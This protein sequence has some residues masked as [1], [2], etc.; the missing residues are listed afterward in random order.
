MSITNRTVI[1]EGKIID[2]YLVNF[3]QYLD[4]K[5]N[6]I[7]KLVI[8]N[9]NSLIFNLNIS[10]IKYI[11][12]PL[13]NNNNKN[14][15]LYQFSI[16]WGDG[17]YEQYFNQQQCCHKYSSSGIYKIIIRGYYPNINTI[18]KKPTKDFR[19][20]LINIEQL[21]ELTELDYTFHDCKLLSGLPKQSMSDIITSCCSTFYGCNLIEYIP[22]EFTLPRFCKSSDSMF[23]GCINLT[24]F[25]N[26]N[27]CLPQTI[28]NCDYMFANTNIEKIPDHLFDTLYDKITHL[29]FV[30][31]ECNNLIDISNFNL[32][33]FTNLSSTIDLFRNCENLHYIAEDY[34]IPQQCK[35]IRGMFSNCINLT[36]C[37]NIIFYHDMIN[38][39]QVFHNCHKLSANIN[40]I[41]TTQMDYLSANL[42]STFFR[43][44]NL[45]GKA[46]AYYLWLTDNIYQQSGCFEQC[47][48]L[49]N[50]KSIPQYWRLNNSSPENNHQGYF[51]IEISQTELL[52]NNCP[53]KNS[54][55]EGI[56]FVLPIYKW[57]DQNKTQ[58]AKY[59][60]QINY[61]D[62]D[63]WYPVNIPSTFNDF[64]INNQFSA[65]EGYPNAILAMLQNA[66]QDNIRKSD[67]Y[68]QNIKSVSMY[69]LNEQIQRLEQIQEN[70]PFPNII[71]SIT[72][73]YKQPG[74]YIITI[75]GEC[76][77]L[78][79]YQQDIWT[80]RFLTKIYSMKNIS[81]YSI[82]H[83]FCN[84]FQLQK[85][86]NHTISTY[87]DISYAFYIK[88]G[89]DN[90]IKSIPPNFSYDVWYENASYAFYNCFVNYNIPISNNFIHIRGNNDVQQQFM[91]YNCRGLSGNIDTTFNN[92]IYEKHKGCFSYCNRLNGYIPKEWKQNL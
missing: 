1:K 61:G 47:S 16:D 52:I 77:R 2:N 26:Q 28:N 42:L 29:H 6:S 89:Y 63:F 66:D 33:K 57:L 13:T 68:N 37:G 73:V 30:F 71:K 8:N 17:S 65:Y 60:F 20:F 22:Y 48:S 4:K 36:N 24:F 46:P 67:N 72:H 21:G 58:I 69:S 86:P 87:Q 50:Y 32:N 84:A 74:E 39:K 35:D 44:Y 85:L 10:N 41:I 78:F 9:S 3:P 75:K 62:N 25:Q 34:S 91:F 83:S 7:Y 54:D 88:D 56:L 79:V 80:N 76:P 43:C 53:C 18:W 45:Q 19:N 40:N 38:C 64:W 14:Q 59:N 82:N 5:D 51:E 23:S 15:E 49:I 11:S 31:Y 55:I 92:S 12:I 70:Y 81:L 27:F 90:N